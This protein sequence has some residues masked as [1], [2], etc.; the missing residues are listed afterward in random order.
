MM[1]ANSPKASKHLPGGSV[2]GWYVSGGSKEKQLSTLV[3]R[4]KSDFQIFIGNFSI[5]SGKCFGMPHPWIPAF[6]G[7]TGT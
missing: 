4:K 7:M 1:N 5:S 2:A 3:V 6:A